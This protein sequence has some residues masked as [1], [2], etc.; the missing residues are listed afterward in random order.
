[1]WDLHRSSEPYPCTPEGNH[2]RRAKEVP[3]Q[4]GGTSPERQGIE[5]GNAGADASLPAMDK[6][7]IGSLSGV[8]LPPLDLDHMDSF[9]A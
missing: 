1:M 4:G 7:A 5:P 3:V 9:A 6:R 8:L 2:D